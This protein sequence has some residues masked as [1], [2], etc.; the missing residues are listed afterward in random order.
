MPNTALNRTLVALLTNKSGGALAFGDVVILDNTNDNG[1]TT[2][3][4]AALSTRQIGVIIEPNGIAN[5][6]SG[7]VATGGWVP[8]VNLNTAAT[9]GQFLKTHTV[10]G[11]ATPHSSPQAEGDFAVA[12]QASATPS[13]ILFGGPNGPGGVS[14]AGSSGDIQTNNGA[15][16]LGSITPGS[17]VSTFLATPSGANLASA[18]TTAL[19]DSKG[20]TGLT[21]LGT[22][23]ATFLGTPS[24]ANLASALT[25][26]L[27]ATKGGT[28]LTALGTGIATALGINVGSAGAPVVLDGALG[29]PSSGVGTNLTG[30]PLTTALTSAKLPTANVNV[31]GVVQVVNTITGAVATGTGQIPADD[32]KPQNS[33]GDEYMTLAVTPRSASNKLRID[34]IVFMSN[35]TATRT[36]TAALF[37]DSGADALAIVSTFMATAAGHATLAF[38]HYMAAGT[39]SA[40]TFKVRAGAGG[41]GTTTFNG[42]LGARYFGG[43]IASSITITEIQ[44]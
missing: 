15:G 36:L 14:V 9:R 10:A 23:V 35:S 8:Q 12:L 6:A 30:I 4:T 7:T 19:P 28:G 32:T 24:G 17:G 5:N 34:V 20:G 21:A 42:I 3:T 43:S 18:L 29:T 2:T 22:G 37:Q 25:T 38:S 16:G 40:T 39:T 27:P 11:Q 26:A 33:E 31:G 44:Q 41:S 1:F 13:A